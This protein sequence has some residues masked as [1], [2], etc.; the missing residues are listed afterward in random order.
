MKRYDK[1]RCTLKSRDITLS[2]KVC[3]VKDMVFLVVT[4]RWESWT[5]KKAE[6]WRI[7]AFELWGW[8][9]LLRVPLDCKEIKSVNPKG[10]QLWIL[11]GKD[12]AAGKDWRQKE[13]RVAEDEIVSITDSKYMNLSKLWEI[14]KDREACHAAVNGVTG[15]RHNS[16]TEKWVCGLFQL[17]WGRGEI[18][19]NWIPAYFLAFYLQPWHCLVAGGCVI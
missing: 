8:R 15:V 17:F 1:P 7:N 13:K 14:V 6:H 4:Y 18:S 2:T 11:I 10:N 5:I 9:R 16:G 3:I 19:R 12:S